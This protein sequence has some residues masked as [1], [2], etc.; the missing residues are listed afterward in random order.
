[1][2]HL[3]KKLLPSVAVTLTVT[4]TSLPLPARAQT[5]PIDCAILLC[6]SGGWPASVPCSL[7]RVEFIR[8]ITPWPVEPPLQ[9]WRCPMGASYEGVRPSSST[10]GIFEAFFKSNSARPRQS[11][12]THE[13][14]GL[15]E[16][17]L[18]AWR[19]ADATEH[20]VP[21]DQT[22]RLVQDRA[23]IDISGPDFNF[24]RSI[25][26]FDVRHAQQ[27]ESGSDDDCR[28]SATVVLGTYGT[29]GDFAW[30]SSSVTALPEAHVG[31]ERWGQNCPTIY[32]RSVFV[33]WRD[34]E[35]NYGFEQVNY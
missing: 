3:L 15:D 6:L 29:Q 27:H 32:H 16:P 22:L 26:V 5:Y 18:A 19:T 24:V 33:D 13:V 14:A 34:Y 8:R 25:R 7:A 20:L 28:R 1:M 2:R 12:A 10:D 30:H 9:I 4:G 31:L 23:D 35:G 11:F 21:F 17:I